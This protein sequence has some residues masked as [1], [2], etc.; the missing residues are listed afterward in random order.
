MQICGDAFAHAFQFSKPFLA[1]S[2]QRFVRTLALGNVT[3]NP[4]EVTPFVL[5]E[6]PERQLEW[7]LVSIFVYPRQFTRA[8]ANV[9]VARLY[10]SAKAGPMNVSQI[11]RHKH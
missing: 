7:H 10:I 8:P 3:S 9:F 2:A 6:F 4:G 5:R 11:F 1:R